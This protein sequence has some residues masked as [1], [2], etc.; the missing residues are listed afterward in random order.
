M[1]TKL[2]P[3]PGR[4]AILAPSLRLW[5]VNYNLAGSMLIS[6]MGIPRRELSP[7]ATPEVTGEERA[8]ILKGKSPGVVA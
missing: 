7:R 5:A 1:T 2:Q 8:A 4:A 6:L 3:C